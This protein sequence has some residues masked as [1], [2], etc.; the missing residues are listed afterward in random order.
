MDTEQ[1][2]PQPKD[3]S[4]IDISKLEKFVSDCQNVSGADCA[5]INVKA[6]LDNYQ[7]WKGI[8]E[9]MVKEKG[10]KD[11]KSGDDLYGAALCA[12]SSC[13]YE[14]TL[15]S[16]A[17]VNLLRDEATEYESRVKYRYLYKDALFYNLALCLTKLDIAG[18]EEIKN[19][20]KKAIYYSVAETNHTA[21]TVDCFAY[22][23]T[24]DYMLKS[25]KEETLSMSPPTSFNDP[26]DCPILELL[27]LYGDDISKLVREIYTECLKVTCFVNNVK[28]EPKFDET[29]RRCWIPKHNNDPAEYLNE[30]MWA[31][32]A[33]NHQ[34]ICVKYHFRNDIT[35]FVDEP[36]GQIAYFRDI[37]YTSDMDAYRKNGAINLKDA[38]FIKGKAWEYENE[39]RLLAFDPNGNGDYGC[40]NAKNSVAAI[41]FG[42]KCPEDKQRKIMEILKGR[43]WME[44]INRWDST[45]KT[46][47]TERIEHPIEYYRMELDETQFGKLKAVK[48]GDSVDSP[49]TKRKSLINR[50]LSCFKKWR[51]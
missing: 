35:K 4:H 20:L 8:V 10:S 24:S 21:Y 37:E 28:L 30:L 19:F 13:L 32:Y 41:Y 38:F 7:E 14:S 25:L 15:L 43:K 42:L 39:L 26:Y 46:M 1:I 6:F 49:H 12:Y 5:D 36:K 3:L 16:K 11:V 45:S 31:H 44:V 48:I 50:I 23:S 40:I 9:Y 33:N 17:T 34:G 22:R 51:R 27:N 47:V 29:H 18:K 2:K